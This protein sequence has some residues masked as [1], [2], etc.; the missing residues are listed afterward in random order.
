MTSPFEHR[1]GLLIASG[2]IGPT[3]PL[4]VAAAKAI[5]NKTTVAVE[6]KKMLNMP[7][8][9]N[10]YYLATVEGTAQGDV[11][12]YWDGQNFWTPATMSRWKQIIL[13]GLRLSRLTCGH[14]RKNNRKGPRCQNQQPL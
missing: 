7:K 5:K 12:V 13:F 9:V 2:S 14:Y 4:A 1:D 6:A 11:I 8:R 10:G 3:D